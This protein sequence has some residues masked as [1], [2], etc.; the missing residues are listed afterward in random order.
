MAWQRRR[1]RPVQEPRVRSK[2]VYKERPR[3][4]S[5]SPTDPLATV[6]VHAVHPP[7]PGP[8]TR[9]EAGAACAEASH[10]DTRRADLCLMAA[11]ERNSDGRWTDES[12]RSGG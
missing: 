1:R 7:P 3:Y 8:R 4:R 9:P 6:Q 2:Y 11:S 12:D 10:L 5:I